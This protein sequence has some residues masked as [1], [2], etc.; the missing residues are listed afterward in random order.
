MVSG[1]YTKIFVDHDEP[2]EILAVVEEEWE[3]PL[4]KLPEGHEYLSSYCR[5][6]RIEPEL[7]RNRIGLGLA[8]RASLYS[9]GP[10]LLVGGIR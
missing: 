5:R 9:L 6:N 3:R 1:V 7:Q 10:L 8:G 4:G 2:L